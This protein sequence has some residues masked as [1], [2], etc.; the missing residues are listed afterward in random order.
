MTRRKP[1]VAAESLVTLP[2]VAFAL[3]M[4]CPTTPPRSPVALS[5]AVPV[6]LVAGAATFAALARGVP[7]LRRRS[8][9]A[10]G[11]G[12][13]AAV[14]GA[15]EEAIW[16]G[17]LLARIAPLVGIAAALVVTTIG[18]AATHFPAL[19]HVG[20]GVH[21]GTGTVFGAVFVA[22]GS[23]AACAAAH[24]AYN[25]LALLGREPRAAG[26]T[27]A[28]VRAKPAV[29]L[30]SIVKRFGTTTALDGCTFD[31]A[32]GEIVALL[33][34]NGAGKTTAV[35]VL[36]GLRRPDAGVVELFGRDPRAWQARIAVG[37]T[38][39]EMSFPPTLRVREIVDFA[40]AHYPQPLA[41]ET[42]LARFGLDE[43]ARRQVGGISGGQ[44]RRLAVALAFAGA[45]RLAVLDEPTSGLDVESRRAVWQAVRKHAQQGG[46]VLL[47][48]HHLEEAESLADRIVV[49]SRGS[50][51][52]DGPAQSLIADGETL[53]D[54]YLRLTRD[55]A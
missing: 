1:S 43:V 30:E 24:A 34:P 21:L 46:A 47:T 23:L 53:E 35:S 40:R 41:T 27:I 29:R 26:Q 50:V 32:E 37:M 9:A 14:A 28:A 54:A 51:V 11:A 8:A 39:Q 38:P 48:T 2:L 31:V 10:V 45:P 36:L 55:G 13:T 5:A 25:L 3:L 15:S 17:F 20:V 16:R 4:F 52:A 44:R 19:R 42:L 18:F 33:G 12:L 6:G 7:A 49:A 22:T